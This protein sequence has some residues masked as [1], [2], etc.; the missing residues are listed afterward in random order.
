ML[1]IV[2]LYIGLV[3]VVGE[4]IYRYSYRKRCNY[5]GDQASGSGFGTIGRCTIGMTFEELQKTWRLRKHKSGNG[6]K[7][8]HGGRDNH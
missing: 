7:D 3:V 5:S 2:I 6:R 1:L 4:I 8:I